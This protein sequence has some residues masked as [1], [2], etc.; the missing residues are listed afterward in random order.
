[1]QVYL[2][3]DLLYLYTLYP[4]A[5]STESQLTLIFDLLMPLALTL[6]GA[7]TS[8]AVSKSSSAIVSE[9]GEA[10]CWDKVFSSSANPV[11]VEN[12]AVIIITAT[13]RLIHLNLIDIP[14]FLVW[15]SFISFQH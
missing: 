11:T 4:S 7:S 6:S 14:F 9:P 5:L 3:F 15:T 12:T 2:P 1:M 10:V 8:S 13:S